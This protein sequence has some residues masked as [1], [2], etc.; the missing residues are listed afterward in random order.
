MPSPFYVI[1]FETTGINPQWNRV[2]EVA[3]VKI[4]DGKIEDHFQSLLNPHK[5]VPYEITNFTGIS[6]EMVDGAPSSSSVMTKLRRYIGKS[7]LIAHNASFDRRFFRK[8]MELAGLNPVNDFL[9]TIRLARKA[10]PGAPRYSL[11]SLVQYTG[12]TPSGDYHR[13]LADATAAS[14]LF[15]KMQH[16]IQ[17][18]YSK[19][20]ASFEDL[21]AFL[22]S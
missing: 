3:V 16:I 6:Q 9:C 10:Y 2:I 14:D 19:P 20:A 11:E 15:I 13:A 1:D 5:R 22:S 8:E 4:I 18:D 12:I 21:E 7:P 17:N